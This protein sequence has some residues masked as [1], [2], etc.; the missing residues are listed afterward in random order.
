MVV[1]AFVFSQAEK[2]GGRGFTIYAMKGIWKR[3][4]IQGYSD[5][6]KIVATVK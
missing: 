4:K 2:N 3:E 5:E 1:N 6:K